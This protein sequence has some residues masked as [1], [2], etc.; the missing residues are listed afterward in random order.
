MLGQDTVSQ[1]LESLGLEIT[2]ISGD[3]LQAHCPAH[4]K[5]TGKE[6]SNPS[7]YINADTGMHICFSCGFKGSLEYLI[8]VVKGYD[9]SQAR[10]YIS[11]ADSN[12]NVDLLMERLEQGLN[13]DAFPVRRPMT[14]PRS[15]MALF[16]PPP[17]WALRERG[18]TAE[19]CEAYGVLWDKDRDAWITPFYDTE[20]GTLIGWQEKGAVDRWFKNVPPMMKKAETLFGW[21]LAAPRE[22]TECVAVESP[23]DAVRVYAVTGIVGL[24]FCG[25]MPST[26]QQ[27]LL[28]LFR[29][30]VLAVDNP[31]WDDAGRKA[32]ESLRGGKS[33]F[34]PWYFQ[35]GD[36][37]AKDPGEMRARDI[38]AG[39]ENAAFMVDKLGRK[40]RT[41]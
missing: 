41:P 26:K 32:I 24:A 7:W 9:D 34:F 40:W 30:T 6:D 17:E 37:D 15:R 4:K 22:V 3:E 33:G 1:L 5:R 11:K 21:P 10:D 2:D 12:I 20:D 28:S 39:I 27:Y 18:L 29:R 25:S 16:V 23:L 13:R 35:Y 19:A 14:V 36:T 8:M 38:R 31:R